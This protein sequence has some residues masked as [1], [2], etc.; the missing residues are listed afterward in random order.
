VAWLVRSWRARWSLVWLGRQRSPAAAVGLVLLLVTGLLGSAAA[1]GA[2]PTIP[3]G[4]IYPGTEES[5]D[6]HQLVH[7][8]LRTTIDI[9]GPEPEDKVRP[10]TNCR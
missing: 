5:P 9:L 7:Q 8:R 2:G 3:D 6:L 4:F 10:Q 1:C